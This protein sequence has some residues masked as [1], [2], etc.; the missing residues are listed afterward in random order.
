MS[1][2][3]ANTVVLFT[4]FSLVSACTSPT[5]AISPP[6]TAIVIHFQGGEYL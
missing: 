6:P 2:S 5:P 4:L 1:K 3:V